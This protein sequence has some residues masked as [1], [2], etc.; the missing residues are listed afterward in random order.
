MSVKAVEL[1]RGMGV[2]YKDKVWVVFSSQHVAKGNKRSYMQIELKA[3][4]GGQLIKERFRVDE[5]LEEAFFERKSM[6][7][8]YSDGDSHVVM[9]GQSFEQ[10]H[11]PAKLIGEK[12]VYLAA[13]I[14]LEV[15]IGRAHV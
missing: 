5:Q 11:L 1:R 6:E 7:Y 2:R 14:Q 9:D 4:G 13:N 8:L 10:V 15:E 12:S 3:A